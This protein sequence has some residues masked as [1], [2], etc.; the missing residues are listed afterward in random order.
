MKFCKL[1]Q[2]RGGVSSGE[3]NTH[4]FLF[5]LAQSETLINYG[6]YS[7]CVFISSA[8]PPGLRAK[9]ASL[10][11]YTMSEKENEKEI[12]DK[13][14]KKSI[15]EEMGRVILNGRSIAIEC[16][17]INR[18]A[19]VES[20]GGRENGKNQSTFASTNWASS[21]TFYFS[22]YR[23]ASATFGLTPVSTQ[24]LSWPLLRALKYRLLRD[25]C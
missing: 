17:L 22:G 11:G 9:Q 3:A 14:G 25:S 18:F 19:Y 1:K 13:N 16:L 4:N 21:A 15:Y 12:N 7:T 2:R 8:N 20:M 23:V 5:S 6:Y 24:K 10:L